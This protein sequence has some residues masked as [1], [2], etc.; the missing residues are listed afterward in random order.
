MSR[1]ELLDWLALVA[2][3]L[4]ILTLLGFTAAIMAGAL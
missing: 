4:M 1:D 3:V 2:V